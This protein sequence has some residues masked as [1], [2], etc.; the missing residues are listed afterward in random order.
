MYVFYF[1][2]NNFLHH[3]RGMLILD[4]QKISGF[5]RFFSFRQFVFV[6]SSHTS[7]SRSY[8]WQTE[9]A[10]RSERWTLLGIISRSL[11]SFRFGFTGKLS[12][13]AK[14]KQ[15]TDSDCSKSGIV[16]ITNRSFVSGF[17]HCYGPNW[18]K[19]ELS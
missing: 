10:R 9:R 8:L 6:P 18:P 15:L 2:C 5:R 7:Q 12:F 3:K 1:P 17:Q 4:Q 13:L 19:S 14:K 11:L 16:R